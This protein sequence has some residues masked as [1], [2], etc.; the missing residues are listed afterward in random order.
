[1]LALAQ[2]IRLAATIVALIIVAAIVLRLADA[3]AANSIVHDIHTA[4]ST[5]A[6]PFKGIFS[7]SNPKTS[8]AVNWGLAAVIYF[9]VGHAIATLIARLSPRGWHRAQP[10]A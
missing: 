5:L 6:G 7:I 8:M 9:V 4:G 3:N 2:L 10:V 1:V